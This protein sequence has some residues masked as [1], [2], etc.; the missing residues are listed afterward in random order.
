MGEGRR[1]HLGVES[2][3]SL[4]ELLVVILIIGILAAIAVPSFV[5]QRGK[6]ND[7]SARVVART[8]ATAAEVIAS[9]NNGSYAAATTSSLHSVEPTLNITSSTTQAYL[10][11]AS[12][13]SNSFTVVAT[14]PVTSDSFTWDNTSGIVTR[15]CSGS[16]SGCSNGTW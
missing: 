4:I 3:F 7:A 9:D 2:G 10:A 16:G 15:S 12:G 1:S 6:A 11:S 5:N 8:A 13:M 14:D